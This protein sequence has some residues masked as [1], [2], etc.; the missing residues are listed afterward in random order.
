MAVINATKVKATANE[1]IYTFKS[2]FKL[3]SNNYIF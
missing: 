1:L 3:L 2:N